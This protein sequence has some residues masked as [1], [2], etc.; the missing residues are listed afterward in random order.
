MKETTWRKKYDS[1]KCPVCMSIFERKY[2]QISGHWKKTTFC[3]SECRGKFFNKR[4]LKSF[5]FGYCDMCS[6]KFKKLSGT[7]RFCGSKKYK[8]GCSHKRK[9]E[10]GRKTASTHRMYGARR[11]WLS[12]VKTF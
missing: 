3:S 4:A 6:R 10:A 7:H 9:L 5:G 12:N 1:K 8:R 11:L 2:M